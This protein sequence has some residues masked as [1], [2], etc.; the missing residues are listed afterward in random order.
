MLLRPFTFALLTWALIPTSTVAAEAAQAA[1]ACIAEQKLQ[2]TCT[3]LEPLT[4]FGSADTARNVAGGASIISAAEL[5]QFENS[6]VARA[7]RRVPGV[8]L[9]LEDGWAL[10]PN[11]S[12]R[13]TASERSSRVTLMEDGVLISPAPYA[14]PSAYYFPTFGRIHS[15]EVLKG[16]ASITQGPYTIGGAINFTS[17][18]IPDTDLGFLQGEYGSDSTWR[19][20]G[21][22]GGSTDRMGYLAE[23]HQWRSDGYQKIDRSKASTGLQK[24]DYL[25]KLAIYSDPAASYYQSLE[26]K[27]QSSEEDSQQSY[28]GLT[29]AD[30]RAQP[31]RRYGLSAADE[32]HNEHQQITLSWRIENQQGDGL[33]ITAYDN[34]FERAWYKTEAVDLNGSTTP[35]NFSGVGW[36]SIIDAINRGVDV[37][38]LSPAG[39]QAILDGEDT[40]EGAIQV[41]NN[42]RSYYSRGIQAVANTSVATGATLHELQVGVRLHKDQEDRLQRNDNYQQLAGQLVLNSYGLEGNAGNEYQD[43]KAWAVYMQDRIELGDWVLT[44]GLRYENI[45]LSRVRYR[46]NSA[47]PAS[48]D[49]ANFRDSRENRVD[50]WLPGLGAIYAMNENTQLVSGVHRGFSTPGNQPGVDPE[51]STNYELG[52]RQQYS[53]FDFEAM[54]FYN[55]YENLVGVCTNSSGS[56]CEPGAAFNGDGVHIPGLELTASTSMRNRS[57]WEFPLQIT[58]TWMKPE[59]Q[60]DFVSD[61]F[62]AVEKGD[63]V[64]YIAENQLWASAGMLRGPWS[65]YL[66]GNYLDSI[67]TQAS[68]DEF[69]QAESALLFDLSAHFEISS[70]WTVYALVENLT[71]QMDIVAR[72]PYGARP[73]KPRTFILGTRLQF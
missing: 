7:L 25:A 31:L 38:G 68:C 64:P 71:D 49:P 28:L 2:P 73:G 53:D 57:G 39:L 24:Q 14:A 8:S 47:D 42:A 35:Q 17:T 52:V 37:G 40:A 70:A 27:L 58:Y 15:V 20:H 69:E 9:Q 23:T 29:D 43:A 13:G 32:M 41:R 3:Q 21:W 16:P 44:P 72:E 60:T 33:S 26:L 48:R 55:D 65:V 4:I 45:Q 67:C 62:G 6:D 51:E 34:D 10:R 12:I 5:E 54:L 63:P 1:D 59:F 66:S 11:I 50:I 36:A 18:P 61:F 30:F 46:T 56:D 22:Y 19:V